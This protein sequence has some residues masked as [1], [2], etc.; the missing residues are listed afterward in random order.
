[1]EIKN[2]LIVFLEA[3]DNIDNGYYYWSVP[4]YY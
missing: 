1:M 2:S 3:F 4:N